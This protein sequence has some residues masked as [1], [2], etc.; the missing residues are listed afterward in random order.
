MD[1]ELDCDKMDYLLRDSYYCGVS[2]GRYDL[3]RLISSLTAYKDKNAKI[4][5]LS[6]QSGGVQAFEAFV[7]ARYF[8]FIQVYFHKTR[9][10]FDK[11]LINALKE[12]LP[13]E[14]YPQELSEYLKWDD[15][16][17]MYEMKMSN[18]VYSQQYLKREAMRCIR[19]SGA[20][21]DEDKIK[22]WRN[23]CKRINKD[24]G[25]EVAMF[26]EIDK[27]AHRLIPFTQEYKSEIEVNVLD[28]YTGEVRSI[29][30]DSRI[31]QGI[32]PKIS[33][34]RVYA[35]ECNKEKIARLLE[36]EIDG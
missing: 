8:M 11:V 22:L 5:Q 4:L 36:S 12:I 34:C 6:I 32:V 30:G 16:R 28:R 7:L 35:K 2:Y 15:V 21:A 19:E 27:K 23:S 3:D 18:G 20:H 26:D 33:I 9:R 17:V 10:Y 29:M 1:G 14:E 13:D 31:L 24:E 25:A